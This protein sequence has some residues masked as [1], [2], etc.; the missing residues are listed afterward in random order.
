MHV[1]DLPLSKMN[2]GIE[3]LIGNKIG[4]FYEMDMEESGRSWGATMRIRVAINVTSPLIRA[5]RIRTT[6]GEELVVSFTY[7]RLQNLCYL[8]GHLRHISKFCEMRFEDGFQDPGEETPYGPW[9]QAPMSP[10]G[11][12]HKSSFANLYFQHRC[13]SNPV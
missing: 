10:W 5:L 11:T 12:N 13:N 6:M 4:K 1:H 9:L 2:L 8:C 7:E 3:T